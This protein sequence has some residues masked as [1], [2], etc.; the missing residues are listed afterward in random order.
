MPSHRQDAEP[1]AVA[2][3][4]ARNP[5]G[6]SGPSGA[7]LTV[8][9][10]LGFSWYCGTVVTAVPFHDDWAYIATLRE[11]LEGRQGLLQYLLAL[12]NG[13]P[14][15]PG[16]LLF[17]TSYYVWD[18]RLEVLRILTAVTLLA[19]A[20]VLFRIVARARDSAGDSTGAR[21]LFFFPCLTL[22]A[23]LGHWEILSLASTVSNAVALFFS[24]LAIVLTG[25]GLRHGRA[26]TVA[27]GAVSAL[28]AT[29]SMSH[30]S[31]TWLAMA[32]QAA[33]ARRPRPWLAVAFAIV[34]VTLIAMLAS[35]S[36]RSGAAFDV[37][38]FARAVLI[39]IGTGVIGLVDN[40]AVPGLNLAA[41]A[42]VAGLAAGGVLTLGRMSVEARERVNESS[43]LIVLGL[44]SVLALAYGR[45]GFGA[46]YLASSRYAA[47]TMPMAAGVYLFWLTRSHPGSG[48]A[49]PIAAALVVTGATV[50]NREEA[51]MARARA[52]AMAEITRAFRC[53]APDDPTVVQRT[54]EDMRDDFLVGHAF[55]ET[56]RLSIFSGPF[57]CDPSKP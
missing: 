42:I 37:G 24:M 10:L 20:A 34:G 18:L 56:R 8:A 44:L 22:V 17:L 47:I 48:L 49:L 45:M 29:G 27:L 16:R 39:A 5:A 14:S 7:A 30:G 51:Q 41:G 6:F 25:D 9:W 31:L 2:A 57:T 19:S 36:P 38:L 26:R 32:C 1:A 4:R 53:I 15:L 50:T 21:L 54:I 33:I 28:A 12:H 46:D 40:Q 11:Y 3:G 55:I 23:S 52:N 13:H 43:G 35:A